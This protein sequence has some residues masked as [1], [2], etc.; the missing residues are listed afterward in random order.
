MRTH[1]SDLTITATIHERCSAR[2]PP[3]S[4]ARA[5]DRPRHA[6][7]DRD[8]AAAGRRRRG[9]PDARPRTGR[10][11][12]PIT[13]VVHVG[14]DGAGAARRRASSSTSTG[15]CPSCCAS[16][17]RHL[18]RHAA[19]RRAGLGASGGAGAQYAAPGAHGRRRRSA[20]APT[21]SPTRPRAT[22]RGHARP[23][24]PHGGVHA[25]RTGA[26]CRARPCGCTP[27]V[28]RRARPS[29]SPLARLDPAPRF[30][31]YAEASGGLGLRVTERAELVPALQRALRDRAGRT[32]ART[33]RC[34]VQV[35]R[36][37][38]RLRPARGPGPEGPRR[39]APPRP[40]AARPV[41]RPPAR[42]RRGGGVGSPRG[43]SR[44]PGR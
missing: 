43:R 16:T 3:R 12:E 4:T 14:R 41:R 27:T 19:R 25:T 29:C 2:S 24:G 32:P 42:G 1:R 38:S 13:K 39:P 35:D 28:T 11:A 5:R 9:A 10:R 23:A 18:L 8:A 22:R 34:G 7:R 30:A 6:A 33:G 21:C 15:R 31:A 26:R 20:T 40:S 37:L 36:R 44:A 17:A